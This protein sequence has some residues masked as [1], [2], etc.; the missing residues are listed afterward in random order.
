VKPAKPWQTIVAQASQPAVSQP[1]SRSVNG[2]SM[3]SFFQNGGANTRPE[4]PP[5]DSP[6]QRPGFDAT[7]AIKRCKRATILLL[8]RR[9]S[10]V[11]A[12]ASQPAVYRFPNLRAVSFQPRIRTCLRPSFHRVFRDSFP[13]GYEISGLAVMPF[14]N[15]NW[16]E[17]DGKMQPR[18]G[19]SLLGRLPRVAPP[20]RPWA[21]RWNPFGMQ[22][23][24]FRKALG[25]AAR[26]RS[27]HRCPAAA[28]RVK[29]FA[30]NA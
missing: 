25:L 1:L 5:H 15:S 16:P 24:N 7:V 28:G 18:W 9:Y 13:N 3:A 22:A 11:V 6:G 2:K 14:G 12:Q 20:S 30:R 17:I 19:R 8:T 21:E 27:S 10:N 23:R 4:R 26:L 29:Y